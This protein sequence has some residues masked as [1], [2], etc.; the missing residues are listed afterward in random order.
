MSPYEGNLMST[1]EVNPNRS[2]RFLI[3]DDHEIL[4]LGFMVLMRLEPSWTV[5][6]EAG[7][8]SNALRLA[9]ELQPDL[10]VVDLRLAGGD[11][12][13]LVKDLR[14]ESPELP[15]LVYSGGNE[16]VFAPRA[17]QAG[18]QGFIAKA[19]PIATL[20][21]AIHRVLSGGIHLSPRMTEWMLASATRGGRPHNSPLALLSD[22]E[23]Q[24][25]EMLGAGKTIKEIAIELHLSPKTVEYHREYI[26]KKLDLPHS[27]AVLQHATAWVLQNG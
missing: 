9:R 6:G 27:S 19:E 26:K 16:M 1:P 18:A 8:A 10:V 13:E 3:V 21:S 23:L 2:V 14:R 7:N 5:C 4:R 11:G 25:F 22:R 20:R 12:L 24:V 15:I 17:L